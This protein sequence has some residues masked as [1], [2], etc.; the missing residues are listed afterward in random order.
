MRLAGKVA[1]VTGG[2]R[3]I[4]AA[5]V[6][7]FSEEGAAVWF[8]GRRP[9]P[10]EELERE[11]REAGREVTFARCDVSRE[12]DVSGLVGAVV[13]RHGRLDVVVSNAG[14]GPSATV[15][16][17]TLELW[18]EVLDAN[19]T[20]MFLVA[21]HAIPALR[22]SGG[23]SIV[24]LGSTYGVVGAAG[25]TAY[26]V[27]KA[28]AISFSRSLALEVAAD[29]IRVNA[30]CPGATETPMHQEWLAAQPDPEVSRRELL[31]RHPLG[32]L[33]TPAEQAQAALFLASDESQFVTGHALLVDGGYTAI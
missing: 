9:E 26:A 33:S 27:S 10:G 17:T 22:R 5:I 18:R 32:R 21:K 14:I 15:E 24:N 7:L 29:R 2:T 25:S 23:G 3:G 12:A 1:L 4:G 28:A 20:S 8:C 16:R 30:L 13:E 6:R 31:G 19:V 11:L